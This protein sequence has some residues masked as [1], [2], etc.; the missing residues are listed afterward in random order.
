MYL[1]PNE[2][3][4]QVWHESYGVLQSKRQRRLK[5]S[6]EKKKRKHAKK[7]KSDKKNELAHV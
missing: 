6:R 2:N 3:G 5:R 1:R 4:G 7:V